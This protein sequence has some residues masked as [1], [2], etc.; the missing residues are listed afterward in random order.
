MSSARFIDGGGRVHLTF[1][2]GPDPRGTPAVLAALAEAGVAA[3]FF[4]MTT[5][6]REYPELLEA[7]RAGGHEIGLH[8]HEHLRHTDLT[9]DQIRSDTDV[10]LEILED[11]GI[12]PRLWRLPWGAASDA[13]WDIA[14]RRGLTIVGWSADTE[15][16]RGDEADLL[17]DRILPGLVN[18][19]IVL[20][21][22]GIGP[23]ATRPSCAATAELIGPLADHVRRGGLNLVPL[24]EPVA[25]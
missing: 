4:V 13:S 20:A 9:P 5:K 11:L 10:A 1:D 16:W 7:V 2:D 23:G 18:G 24:S 21:H 12:Q 14:H 8:C 15:D 17:L 25:V 19:A 3:T 6:V 22:D